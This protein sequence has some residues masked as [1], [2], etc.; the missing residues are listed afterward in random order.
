MKIKGIIFDFDGLICDTET[1]EL[2]V[3]EEIFSTH[4]LK[5]PQEVYQNSIGAIHGDEKPIQ[6]LE[7]M[8]GSPIDMQELKETYQTRFHL[9]ADQEPLQPGILEYLNDAKRFRLKIGLAS[10]SPRN[11]VFHHIERLGISDRFDCISTKEDVSRTKPDPELFIITIKRLSIKPDEAIALEDSINGVRAA[12]AAGIITIVVP[13]P[14]TKDFSFHNADLVIDSLANFPLEM[15]L[16][17]FT[18]RK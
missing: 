10:S 12:K 8:M 7:E 15:M 17:R 4:N 5:F 11:W 13:N 16:N 9:L 3:W 6:L 18:S 14:V 2:R 1:P